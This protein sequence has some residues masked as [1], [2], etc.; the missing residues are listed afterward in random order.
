MRLRGHAAP[1]DTG[2]TAQRYAG[3]EHR[4][5]PSPAINP[6]KAHTEAP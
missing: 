6:V 2:S 5:K 3:P 1:V 4:V